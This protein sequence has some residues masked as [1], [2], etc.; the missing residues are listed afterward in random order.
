MSRSRKKSRSRLTT[1]ANTAVSGVIG[2]DNFA[3]GRALVYNNNS[4][5]YSY[6]TG[7]GSY[8]I[9]M[10]TIGVNQ[11]IKWNG[12]AWVGGADDILITGLVNNSL[13]L[14]NFQIVGIN[15]SLVRGV[16]VDNNIMTGVTITDTLITVPVTNLLGGTYFV[17]LLLDG[18]TRMLPQMFP[19]QTVTLTSS[20]ASISE[21]SSATVTLSSINVPN[22][23]LLSYTITGTANLADT[24]FVMSTGILLVRNNTATLTVQAV[25]DALVEN[26]ETIIITL[27][28][29]GVSI[30]INIINVP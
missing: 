27:D 15:L 22:S 9:D 19:M 13:T 14:K 1:L 21:G 25:T 2:A 28:N 20:A 17:F 10:T 8:A 11:V 5:Q 12:V 30:Y 26:I 6:P 7:F 3:P 4:W 23:T 16:V 18:D 29:T 24:T